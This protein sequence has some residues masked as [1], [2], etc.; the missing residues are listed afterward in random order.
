MNLLGIPREVRDLG[1]IA[2]LEIQ[3]LRVA[4]RR[5]LPAEAG[6]EEPFPASRPALP[7]PATRRKDRRL[8]CF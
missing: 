6:R 3:A 7:N 4:T 8:R 1:A 5:A 2:H